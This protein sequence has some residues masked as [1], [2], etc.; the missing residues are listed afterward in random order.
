MDHFILI[1]PLIFVW[2]GICSGLYT[3]GLILI[4]HQFGSKDLAAASTMIAMAYTLGM[5]MGPA[6]SGAA[7]DVWNPHGMLI[8]LGSTAML[9]LILVYCLKSSILDS[10]NLTC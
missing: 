10:S 2:G 6:I 4:G 3:L 8:S 7:M 1:W 5:I 9:Y